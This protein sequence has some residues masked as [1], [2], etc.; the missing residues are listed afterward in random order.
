MS[1]LQRYLQD[2]EVH[3][4]GEAVPTTR[5][6]ALHPSSRIEVG[7]RNEQISVDAAFEA[8]ENCV[9][10]FARFIG[11][12][13]GTDEV[14]LEVEGKSLVAVVRR[15]TAT[16]EVVLRLVEDTV[17]E[18]DFVLRVEVCGV[19]SVL[20]VRSFIRLTAVEHISISGI[21]MSNVMR[22]GRKGMLLCP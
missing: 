9:V 11:L 15:D 16:T 4:G 13:T 7:G 10:G 20:V 12:L 1:D 6:P 18:S 19:V 22:C 14:T 3:A 8:V 5:L 21:T 2:L 17:V